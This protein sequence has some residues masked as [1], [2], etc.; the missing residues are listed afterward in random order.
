MKTAL[1][2]VAALTLA[3]VPVQAQT[4]DEVQLVLISGVNAEKKWSSDVISKVTFTMPTMQGC[5]EAGRI[6]TL[7][8]GE[9]TGFRKGCASSSA[10]P[11]GDGI[12]ASQLR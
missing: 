12:T 3:A 8:Q 9:K 6:W 4:G 5:I 10:C 11:G 1:V 7:V 2:A